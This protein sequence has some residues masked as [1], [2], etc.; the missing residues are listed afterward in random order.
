MSEVFC[1]CEGELLIS[2]AMYDTVNNMHISKVYT[3]IVSETLNL[4]SNFVFQLIN[5]LCPVNWRHGWSVFC[6]CADD[7]ILMYIRLSRFLALNFTHT[8]PEVPNSISTFV[9][10]LIVNIPSPIDCQHDWSMCEDE[11]QHVHFVG[12]WLILNWLSTLHTSSLK[13]WTWSVPLSWC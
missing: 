9:L 2:L 13:L 7:N 5:I 1:T 6:T 8:V 12:F 4:T 10:M 11:H 3:Y